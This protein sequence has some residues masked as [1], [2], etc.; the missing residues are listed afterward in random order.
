MRYK[1]IEGSTNDIYNI[2]ETIL[3]NRGISNPK[4]YLK[5]DDS[6][7]YDWSLLEN[8]KEA[9]DCLSKHIELNSNIHVVVDPDCDGYTSAASMYKYLKLL[10]PDIKLNY[11]IHSG[12]QHGLT[13]DI[14]IPKETNLL[15]I[16]DAGSNDVEQCKAL[17]EQGIDI[18]VLDHHLCDVK[19]ENA[20]VVNCQMG[21]YPNNQLSGVGVTFKFLQ[22]MDE[23]IWINYSNDFLDLVALGNIADC[24]DIKSYETKRIID[25]GL[26][27]IRNKLFKALIDKQSYSM[28]NTLNIINIQWYIVPLI[29]AMVRSGDYDEKDLMFRA[30]I[31]QDEIFTYKPRRKLKNDPEPK[32]IKEDI[33]TRVA[34][35][36]GNAKGR[37][38]KSKDKSSD[39]IDEVILKFGLDK[40]KII[41]A[42]VTDILDENMTGIV[43]IKVAEKYNKPCLLL[44]KKEDGTYAGS[45]RNID[46]SPLNS[47]KDFLESLELFEY[48]TGHQGAFGVKIHKN[49]ITKAIQLINEKLYNVNF[50][51]CHEVDFIVDINSLDIAFIREIDSLK[52]IYGQGISESKIAIKNLIVNKNDVKLIGKNSN[53][54]K[55]TYNDGI[56]FIKFNCKESDVI[57]QWINDWDSKSEEIVIDVVGKC[58]INNFGG[59]L[60]PQIVIEEYEI[61]KE[62]II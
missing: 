4:E 15:I 38:T 31:E 42:N 28:N 23:K 59:I 9:V 55:L 18:I 43:A 29:N 7:L 61:N 40:N 48:C 49:N 12:K 1:L 22:A 33:Y 11:S 14:I 8:I 50:S 35:L 26:S 5:L 10:K 37:Q 39:K 51:Y 30:F 17:K 44:R 52:N 45:A 6:V 36:C 25:K 19:N 16:P 32:E 46:N 62:S 21:N 58:N 54:V 27:K 2:K 57:I 13:E 47:L 34:R 53:T 3:K 56:V 24:M 60:T 20:I 41:F